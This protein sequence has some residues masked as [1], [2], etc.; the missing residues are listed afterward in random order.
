[1]PGRPYRISMPKYLRSKPVLVLTGPTAS[2][3]SGLAIRLAQALQG[4]IIS[5]DSMQIYQGLDIGTAKLAH[6]EQGGIVHHLYDI[7]KPLDRYSVAD[8]VQ[9]ASHLICDIAD[10]GR[11]P[12]VCGGTGQF[13]T[14]LVD[15]LQFINEDFDPELRAL[16]TRHIAHWGTLPAHE[17]L[18]SLDPDAGRR[19]ENTD[20]KRIVRF[21]E[22]YCKT[23]MTSSEVYHFS[24][25]KGPDFPFVNYVLWPDRQLLYA[26]IEQR[27]EDMFSQGIVEELEQVLAL[28]PDFPH[29]QAFQAI[30]YKEIY[31]YL[32]GE[33]SR[34]EAIANLAQAS[35]RYA[36]RQLTYFRQREDFLKITEP[37]PEEAFLKILQDFKVKTLTW[38]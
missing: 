23:G 21:F 11:Q 5:A 3:K 31:S 10:R 35:R 14:A 22:V 18:S 27:V 28:Y 1:M 33:E 7:R 9:D 34:D 17:R 2:G 20:L 32:Q 12:I 25:E 6:S 24:R 37:N 16:L 4:E 13:V 15:G 38:G 30:A 36:K 8:F 29:S 19:I 26:R